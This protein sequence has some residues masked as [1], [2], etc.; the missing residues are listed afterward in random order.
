[1]ELEISIFDNLGQQWTLGTHNLLC[2]KFAA[3]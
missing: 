2:R 3:V 1:L